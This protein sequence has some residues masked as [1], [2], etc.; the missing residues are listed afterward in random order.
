MELKG[1]TIPIQSREA[2]IEIK[3]K[4]NNLTFSFSSEYPVERWWGREII[5]HADGCC[6]LER[7]SGMNFLWNHNPDQVLGKVERVWFEEGRGYCEVRW[8]NREKV[9]DFKR[10]VEDGILTNVSYM[11]S[12]DEVIE[13]EDDYLVTKWTPYEISLV[14]VPADPSVGVGRASEFSIAVRNSKGVE[15]SG[16]DRQNLIDTERQRI[17]TIQAL[18]E[19]HG[20]PELAHSLISEGKSVDEA[21]AAYLDRVT[22]TPATPVAR[23]IDPLGLSDQEQ[24]NYSL[25]RAIN[26]YANNDWSK[27]GF[28][29]ECSQE[30]AKRLGKDSKGF[31]VPVKDLRMVDIQKRAPYA[32]GASNTG[33]ATIQTDVLAENFIDIL[34][35]R[36]VCMRLGAT[37][38]SGL[39]GNVAIPRQTSATSSYWV[40]ENGAITQSEATFDQLPMSPK[41]IAARSQLSR[42]ILQQSSIDIEQFVRNDFAQIIAL[43]IDRAVIAGTGLNNEPTGILNTAGIGS[44]ALGTNGAAPTWASI[45][46][47]ETEVSQDNADVGRLGYLTNPKVRGTLKT[48]LKSAS[49]VSEFIWQDTS[50]SDGVG[51]VNGYTAMSS[52]QVPSNLTKGTGTGLSAVIFGN[53]ADIIVGEWGVLEILPNPYGAGY[54]SGAV[55]MRVMQTVDIG[56]RHPESFAVITDAVTT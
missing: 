20:F 7:V 34:R 16:E 53:W 21:R 43:G 33:G 29:R 12:I 30:I 31:F 47:L 37:M 4:E 39:T 5:S 10:D 18:K 14:S 28:E 56:I 24:K 48:T 22:S 1:K 54:N 46:R 41:T 51:Q 23:T 6:N 9:A 35:N 45:V 27:A 26:A 2:R 19:R 17:L 49:S 52:N 8:S 13:K 32:A 36:L 50:I 3:S 44:V 25:V 55:D 11:Y 40:A 15:M 42:Q 38:L